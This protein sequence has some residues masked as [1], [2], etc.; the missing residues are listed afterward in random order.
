LLE[1]QNQPQRDH[2]VIDVA[3]IGSR[4]KLLGDMLPSRSSR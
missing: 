2:R 1:L 3:A 4:R